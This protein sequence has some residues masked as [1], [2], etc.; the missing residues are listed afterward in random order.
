MK[1]QLLLLVMMLLPMVAM[2]HDIE[3]V[4]AQGKTIYYV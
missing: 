2:A 4:N 3:V 1:K